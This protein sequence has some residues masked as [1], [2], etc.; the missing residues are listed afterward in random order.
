[1]LGS[2]GGIGPAPG[3][4]MQNRLKAPKV[5]KKL[6]IKQRRAP[7]ASECMAQ[8]LLRDMIGF[9]Q[10]K[11]YRRTNRLLVRCT[12]D[13]IIGNIFNSYNKFTP[14]S[15]KP[16]VVRID[17]RMEF[18]EKAGK[19][20]FGLLSEKGQKRLGIKHKEAKEVIKYQATNFCVIMDNNP[21]PVPYTDQVIAFASHLVQDDK[22]FYKTINR[23][24]EKTFNKIPECAVFNNLHNE[25][26]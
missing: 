5:N 1:M 23:L 14:F 7:F 25:G 12:H 13:W 11:V 17:S 22:A 20:F 8:Q 16:D 26:G 9:E 3:L 2:R 24:D 21:E 19:T 4:P 18:R 6:A 10:W 15:G